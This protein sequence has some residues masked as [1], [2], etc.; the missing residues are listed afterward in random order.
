MATSSLLSSRSKLAVS[1]QNK[2]VKAHG[3]ERSSGVVTPLIRDITRGHAEVSLSQMEEES[4]QDWLI[5]VVNREL[6]VDSDKE[7]D[8]GTEIE[9]EERDKEI[10][11]EEDQVVS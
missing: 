3:K 5:E 11:Q 7:E 4:V 2:A 10:E 6:E 1:V 9:D 8:I